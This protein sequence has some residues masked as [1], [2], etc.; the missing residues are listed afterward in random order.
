[1][2]EKTPPGP[3][4]SGR[5]AGVV[6]I[7]AILVGGYYGLVAKPASTTATTS[8]AAP[9]TPGNK[10]ADT[11]PV[12][13]TGPAAD[14]S[15]KP[16]EDATAQTTPAKTADGS[17]DQTTQTAAI[18]A[19]ATDPKAASTEASKPAAVPAETTA[20]SFD[21][22]R[23][24]PTG[25]TV[26]AGLAAPKAKVELLDGS[27]PIA[28]AEAN[29]RGEWAMAVEKPLAAGTHDLSIRTTS[30]DKKTETL[31]EQS[32]AVQVQEPGKGEALVVLNT[33][34]AASKVLQ[35]PDAAKA[36]TKVA[37]A[38]PDSVAPNANESTP[39]AAATPAG[40]AGAPATSNAPGEATA[41]A[42]ADTPAKPDSAATANAA[43]NTDAAK[44]DAPAG[45]DTLAES[46]KAAQPDATAGASAAA[47]ADAAIAAKPAAPADAKSADAAA[48]SE[49]PKVTVD[50]VEVE[51]GKL[52]VAGSAK[53]K[54]PVRVYVDEKPVGVAK[55]GEGGRW[56]LEAPQTV[57]PGRR[58]VRADQLEGDTGKVVARAEVPFERSPD[59]AV[60]VPVAAG[61]GAGGANADGNVPAPQ[62]VIIRRGDNLWR[63]SRRLYGRG[64]RFSTIYE[65]NND[66][67]RNPDLIYPGQTFVLPTGDANWTN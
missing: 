8:D 16:A 55:P 5:V 7:A 41:A 50:A 48:H 32:V 20:P 10:A 56:L 18:S 11:T 24:E 34:D 45:A 17:S 59:E 29:E 53:T 28:T 3:T 37:A 43:P 39:P 6:A 2:A 51:D 12:A 46:D 38:T 13:K 30:P 67:I 25:E 22:V 49:A 14:G 21:I 9:A 52:F 64:I 35:K 62:N 4:T 58:V 40:P 19:P 42:T 27:A 57:E 47:P 63:I 54:A 33:P 60:L 44:T 31:S 26:V 65:A 36:E 15:A 66:Q 61:G 23:V 1:M